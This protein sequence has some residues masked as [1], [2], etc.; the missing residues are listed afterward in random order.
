MLMPGAVASA[1]RVVQARQVLW[2]SNSFS[3]GVGSEAG[4]A[5]GHVIRRLRSAAP[6]APLDI[7]RGRPK[8]GAIGLISVNGPAYPQPSES[9]F[10]MLPHCHTGGP[11]VLLRTS[12]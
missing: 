5:C 9:T 10:I 2:V 4:R 6:R 8:E 11:T 3:E 12:Q 7:P 1:Y